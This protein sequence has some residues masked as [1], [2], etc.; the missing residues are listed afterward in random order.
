MNQSPQA[1]A[2]PRQPAGESAATH[3]DGAGISERIHQRLSSLS[4]SERRIARVLLSGAPTAGLESSARLAEQAGVSGPTVSRF[5][6]QRLGFRS[7]ADFQ[8]A[9]RDEIEARVVSPVEVYRRQR[10]EAPSDDFAGRSGTTLGESVAQS[11][12]GLDLTEFAQ[13]T[14]LLADVRHHVLALGG[15]FSHLVAG[16]LVGVLREIRPGVRLV[17]PVPAERAAALAD[18]GKRDVVCAFDFRRYERDTQEFAAAAKDAGARVILFTD[19]WLSPI[20]EIAD[21]VL[22]AQVAGPSPFPSLAP[23]VAVAETLI[24]AV[25]GA[26]GDS[27]REHFE[28]FGGIADHWIRF[29]PQRS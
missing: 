4:P 7:Y 25:A 22:P 9:L 20:A 14:A 24:T 18:I 26:L 28:R 12:Q 17:P 2:V 16:Y 1:P 3:P 29:W 13:A 8:R 15:S 21:A 6:T 11:V 19:P 27:A 10:V 23:T 5:V